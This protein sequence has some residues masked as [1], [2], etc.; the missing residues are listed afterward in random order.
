M[1]QSCGA[2]D[3]NVDLPKGLSSMM[4]YVLSARKSP[5]QPCMLPVI[6]KGFN[7][8]VFSDAHGQ[9]PLRRQGNKVYAVCHQPS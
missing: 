3:V 4:T 5:T 8:E 1:T 9:W 6:P 7:L 2:P